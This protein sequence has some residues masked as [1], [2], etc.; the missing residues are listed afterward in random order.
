[1]IYATPGESRVH[2]FLANT[3]LAG[4]ARIRIVQGAATI[5]AATTSGI[6]EYPAS[7]GAYQATFTAPSTSGNYLILID[8][9]AVTPGHLD[10][11]DLVVTYASP[12]VGASSGDYIT[13]ADLKAARELTGY[14]FADGQIPSVITSASRV[15][16]RMCGTRRRFYADADATQV[17]HYTAGRC[18][19]I[20]IDDIITV[21]TIETDNNGD[22]TFETTWAATDYV[23]EPLNAAADS[24]PYESIRV[25]QA[26][27]YRF[28]HFVPGVKVTGK[29]GWAAVPAEV[30][31]ATMLLSVRY[32]LRAREAPSGIIA[33]GSAVEGSV[34][35]LARTDPDVPGL[36][37]RFSRKN[38][39]L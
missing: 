36:L 35:R 12:S 21:T 11:V 26:G 13:E 15:V 23:M 6:V 9:G 34:M 4:T 20:E 28:P 32:L 31:T 16:D 18:D 14:S 22:G 19:R 30:W 27:R 2:G 39:L 10:A 33:I 3:G 37:E 8:D 5:T 17:R 29:F 1:M 7:S 38:P 25:T 24:M